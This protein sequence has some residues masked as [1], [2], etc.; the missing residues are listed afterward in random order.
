MRFQ[1]RIHRWRHP[2]ALRRA[3][4]PRRRVSSTARPTRL[5]GRGTAAFRR[6]IRRGPELVARTS[7]S[8]RLT[9]NTSPQP[10]LR[11]RLRLDIVLPL[12]IL[13]LSLFQN[14][15]QVHVSPFHRDEARWI[16]RA[17]FLGDLTDPFG[18]TWNDY[19]LTNTQA[20]FGSYMMG[21][22]LLLQ[23]RDLETNAIWDFNFSQ[24]WNV[25][26]GAMPVPADLDAG[27]RMNAM[28]GALVA[29]I[30]YF[31]GRRLGNRVGATLAAIFIA[32]HPLHILMSSQA[33]SDVTL[34]FL[35][36]L[37]FLQA[38]RFA[39]RP[40]WPNAILMSI[41]I[42][43][44]GSAKL[45]PLLLSLPLAA[46][47][48]FLLARS[49][50]RRW[51]R[52]PAKDRAMAIRLLPQPVLAF[53]VFVAAFPYLWVDPIGRSYHMFTQRADEM[54]SQGTIWPDLAVGSPLEALARIGLRLGVTSS[55]SGRLG[56]SLTSM[57]SFEHATAHVAYGLDFLPALAGVVLL[58]ALVVR[59]GLRSP[60]ALIALLMGSEVGAIAIGMK[61]DFNR[62][63]LPIVLIMGI[64]IAVSTSTC[65]NALARA[66]AW[67]LLNVLPGVRVVPVTVTAKKRPVHA[68]PMPGGGTDDRKKD[69]SVP[70]AGT[71]REDLLPGAD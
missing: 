62:Y 16:A 25:E 28:L 54:L 60:Y 11:V 57:L 4:A 56:S 35:L 47:G 71:L 23:G 63:H 36:A 38:M 29:V 61:A 10:R 15:D 41:L 52:E 39:S 43:F 6:E 20:P 68:A 55:T 27:R 44:G 13:V 26:N 7:R 51:S 45:S 21:L 70:A 19:Y 66:D 67:K 64:C 53:A 9:A 17:H 30:V 14:L 18:P 1:H 40:T 12:L 33:L 42:G 34:T 3:T 48:G 58:G 8:Y 50:T 31:I 59:Y 46:L 5:L 22:G 49:Y 2:A 69:R 65:W 24:E 32:L 37:L